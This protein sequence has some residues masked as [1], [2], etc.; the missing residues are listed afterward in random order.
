MT[1][2]VGITGIGV[3]GPGLAGWAQAAPVLAGRE[4][5]QPAP[6]VPPAPFMG[7]Q[8]EWRRGARR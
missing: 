3:L 5:H 1:L 2:A 4:A 6:L 7:I 8:E